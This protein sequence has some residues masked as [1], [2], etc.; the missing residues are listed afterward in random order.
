MGGRVTDGG[1]SR[2]Q[3]SLPPSILPVVFQDTAH[4][5]LGGGGRG[6]RRGGAAREGKEQEGDIISII[7]KT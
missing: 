6:G 4:D 2:R 1:I 5:N 3:F 7:P